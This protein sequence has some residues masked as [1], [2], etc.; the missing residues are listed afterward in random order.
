MRSMSDPFLN[1]KRPSW[2]SRAHIRDSRPASPSRVGAQGSGAGSGHSERAHSKYSASGAERWFECPGSVELSEGLP[3]KSS[4]WAEEGTRAHEV[5]EFALKAGL[6]GLD[7]V[8]DP[9]TPEEMV[10][11]AR[12]ARNFLLTLWAKSPTSDFLVEQKVY[13]DF[14]H[15]EAFGTFDAAILDHFGTLHVVDYKYGA[16]VSVSVK[17][18]LQMIF[19]A[20]GLANRYDWNFKRVRMWIIQ[21]RIKGYDGP[22]FWDISMEELMAYIPRFKDAIDRAVTETDTFVEGSHCHWCR[23]KTICPLKRRA[24]EEE[25]RNVFGRS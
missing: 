24:K 4:P 12:N 6:K 22:V 5:L 15:E 10:G 8:M 2:S 13:L 9:G 16:G 20:L 3:S 19:Y 14:I 23:A 1:L 18:N 17:E 11:H 7:F 25:A 21:P